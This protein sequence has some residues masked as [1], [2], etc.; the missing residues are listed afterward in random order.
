MR[1]NGQTTNREIKLKEGQVIISR[2]D[3]KGRITFVNDA[4]VEI[5]GYTEEELLSAPHNILRHPHVPAAAFADLWATIKAG[6]PW[7]GIVKNRAKN[8]DHYWVRANV[9][10]VMDEGKIIGYISIRTKPSD[11]EISFAERLYAD[12]R[13]GRA[14]NV[15]VSNGDVIDT[16]IWPRF[17]RRINSVV[18]RVS[19]GFITVI[20]LSSM[21]PLLGPAVALPILIGTAV[22]LGLWVVWSVSRPISDL[23]KQFSDLSHGLIDRSIELPSITEYRYLAKE[24]R[25]LRAHMIYAA[26][27]KEEREDK[28]RR[29]IRRALLDTAS[30][31]EDDLEVTWVDV[32]RSSQGTSGGLSYL[33]EVLGEVAGSA[34]AAVS[35]A[36]K[37]RGNAFGVA[38]ATEQLTATSEEISRQATLS[39]NIARSAVSGAREAEQAIS[40][41]ETA[42]KEISRAANLIG[43]IAGQTN[44]L[45]L[46][47]TI[48]AA[49]AGEAGRGFA[50][51]AGEVKILAS[52]TARSTEEINTLINDLGVAVSGGVNSI[53]S[54]ISVIEQIE[55]AATATASAVEQQRAANAEIGQ[56]AIA[57]AQCADDVSVNVNTISERTQN[58]SGI[59]KDV[60]FRAIETLQVVSSLKQ[61]LIV[62]LRQSAAGDRRS[63]D[64]IP[65]ELPITLTVD[66]KENAATMMDIS[67]EGFMTG[68]EGLE[69][70]SVE[71]RVD[72]NLGEFG[73]LRAVLVGKS[74]FG[75][76][77]AYER[78]TERQHDC[79]SIAYT[80]LVKADRPFIDAATAMAAKV[81]GVIEAAIGRGDI[82]ETVLFD[83]NLTLIP[84]T[85]PEQYMAPFTELTDRLL[86][87]MQEEMLSFDPRVTFCACV[88]TIGYLP[89]HNRAYS[90]AQR[91]GDREWNVG[92]SRNRRIFNDR[93]GIAAAR[94]TRPFLLQAYRRHMGG[95]NVVRI[96]EVDTPIMINGN[97]WGSLRLAYRA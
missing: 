20:L 66:R 14:R 64:R 94:N 53:R 89:T 31:I 41:M 16:R 96:K 1:D 8:G 93:A 90:E 78:M 34:V 57:S 9:T 2:T 32:E 17:M 5:S 67:T 27:E 76:H 33:H 22:M 49:R 42:T 35:A 47:A 6:H 40:R 87:N 19:V 15:V 26:R 30:G 88:N 73:A 21:M 4:F 61:R 58:L 85:D 51:V 69:H 3:L 18:G 52:Q 97:R 81:A 37:A 92:H 29:A 48:E 43:A 25:A 91:P 46:N 68:M 71:Q 44:L 83:T 72:A 50:V 55:E 65:C 70:L 13:E 39:S 62:T 24:L 74:E 79:L 77:F 95:G 56:N 75:L 63:S 59:A 10:P 28:H 12:I 86:A 7:E 82:T 80:N 36:D 11:D 60:G 84:G 54:V 23:E 45:A 38:A